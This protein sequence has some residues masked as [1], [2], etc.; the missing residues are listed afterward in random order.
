MSEIE[1]QNEEKTFK[2]YGQV[3]FWNE[4][5]K[6]TKV[7]LK[8]NIKRYFPFILFSLLFFLASIAALLP[9]HFFT[10]R[11]EVYLISLIFSLLILVLVFAPSLLALSD[12]MI[13]DTMQDTNQL[14]LSDCK[15]KFKN[16]FNS[17]YGWILRIFARNTRILGILIKTFLVYLI[18][19]IIIIIPSHFIKISAEP[20]YFAVI[21]EL[22]DAFVF[23]N[24]YEKINSL[25]GLIPFYSIELLIV[26][27]LTIIFFVIYSM[28][29][30]YYIFYRI[31][32]AGATHTVKDSKTIFKYAVKQNKWSFAAFFI[33]SFKYFIIAFICL[34]AIFACLFSLILD[35]HLLIF[36]LTYACSVT[37]LFIAVPFFIRVMLN[38][39]I[40]FIDIF[41][42]GVL[43]ALKTK[44]KKNKERD[45][46]LIKEIEHFENLVKLL[47][48]DRKILYKKYK[49]KQTITESSEEEVQKQEEA[50]TNFFE[51]IDK[52]LE[53]MSD[54]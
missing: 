50:L 47:F 27:L 15:T 10:N 48:V 43:E 38:I 53:K 7:F 3:L 35:D 49:N 36:V 18:L 23:Q 5:I 16:Y 1:N 34:L 8:D 28:Y 42:L 45:E 12:L 22:K 20:Q 30:F 51:K 11:I 19:F 44:N 37:G 54:D 17:F 2:D 26:N 33:N 41:L 14:P 52:E 25:L 40:S 21:Q 13:L 4:I 39:N 6:E 29:S 46:N 31:S 9:I 32:A 24:L